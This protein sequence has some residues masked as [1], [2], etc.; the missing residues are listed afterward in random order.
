[1][2]SKLRSVLRQ[3]H[4]S[5][6]LR[7]A[8]FAASWFFLPFWAFLLVAFYLYFVPFF[9]PRRL[10]LP[11]LLVIFF[12]AVLTPTPWF[13]IFLGVAWYL[14]LGIKD[15]IFINRKQAYEI[16]VLFLVFLVTVRFFAHFDSW[17]GAFSVLYSLATSVVVFLLC[18]GFLKYG[19]LP[20]HAGYREK[21]ARSTAAAA[22]VALILFEL[23]LLFLVLPIHFLFQASLFFVVAAIILESVF[24]YV[25]GA[26]TRRIILVN[27]S[28][29]FI[30]LV[31]ILGS[32]QWSL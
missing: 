14:I 5:L 16:L 22:V 21:A 32:A 12:T 8:I 19:D 13:A 1:M 9:Q 24:E 18:K 6:A 23:S 2:G 26:L 20:E 31:I 17:A 7:A 27:F 30:F 3:I 4:W 29:F 28:I 15:L 11:S 25:N 10:A